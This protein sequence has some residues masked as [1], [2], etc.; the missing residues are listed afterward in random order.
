MRRRARLETLE[1]TH[2]AER[3]ALNIATP[4]FCPTD[5]SPVIP[6][7]LKLRLTLFLPPNHGFGESFSSPGPGRPHHFLIR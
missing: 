4:E 6:N 2:D 3:A 5:F 1:I 7:A